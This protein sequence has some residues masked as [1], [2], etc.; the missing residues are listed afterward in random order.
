MAADPIL[1]PVVCDGIC[2]AC[3]CQRIDYALGHHQRVGVPRNSLASVMPMN[4]LK[5]SARAYNRIWKM[6]GAMTD[7][8]F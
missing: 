8:A 2:R 7:L 5:R 1:G 6:A 4:E 3:H